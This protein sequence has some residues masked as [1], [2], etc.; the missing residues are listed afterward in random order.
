MANARAERTW[1]EVIGED[2][3]ENAVSRLKALGKN[4]YA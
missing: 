1:G 2:E 4:P 3:I